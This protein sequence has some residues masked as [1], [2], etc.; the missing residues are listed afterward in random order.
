[1]YF[2]FSCLWVK[3]APSRGILCLPKWMQIFIHA[4]YVSTRRQRR[5]ISS[6]IPFCAPWVFDFSDTSYYPVPFCYPTQSYQHHRSLTAVLFNIL[7]QTDISFAPG[8]QGNWWDPGID[9]VSRRSPTDSAEG[10]I[11]MKV[12]KWLPMYE[13][14]IVKEVIWMKCII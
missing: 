1:M 14:L 13:V 11:L 7:V 6:P 10:R 3:R 8:S 4:G 5:R 9:V 12:S 2:Y